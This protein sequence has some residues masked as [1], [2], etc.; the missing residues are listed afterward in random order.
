MFASLA[1]DAHPSLCDFDESKDLQDGSTMS[2]TTIKGTLLYM[3]PEPERT[4]AS[5]VFSLAVT[6]FDMLWC[7]SIPERLPIVHGKLP[8]LDV[9]AVVRTMRNT[10]QAAA[11][12]DDSVGPDTGIVELLCRMLHPEPQHRPPAVEAA[13]ELQQLVRKMQLKTCLISA[14]CTSDELVSEDGIQCSE[15]H[16]VC[17]ECFSMDV[18][19]RQVTE[20]IQKDMLHVRCCVSGCESTPFSY[21]LVA[22][23]VN[24]SAFKA[25]QDQ[26]HAVHDE[27]QQREFED[28]KQRFEEGLLKK[29]AREL[30]L[31]QIRKHVENE[32][33]TLRCPKCKLAFMEFNGCAA[34]TCKAED[35]KGTKQGGCGCAFCGFCFKD[36][37]ADAHPHV[38][39]C[40]HN[41][42][43]SVFIPLIQW[44][45]AMNERRR[46]IL[47]KYWRG[48][49]D[50]VRQEM[51][52]DGGIQQ[53][54]NDLDINHELQPV[55]HRWELEMVQIMGMGLT[56]RQVVR[57]AL[58]RAE[59]DVQAALVLLELLH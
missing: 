11:G 54:F 38:A 46:V 10:T 41:K 37:G 35:D 12:E 33:M 31:I 53:H 20:C 44:E 21:Q 4:K 39:N 43:R 15:G 55:R 8:P 26:I 2:T 19:M 59:G 28:E 23:H 50:D 27:Q 36:C 40:P 42:S 47:L 7:D 24:E 51:S 16:F 5:D 56:D 34:L 52:R 22:Q 32:I 1:A 6:L 18:E 57:D 58:E 30:E 13:G 25:L 3:P 14:A 9:G 48:L 49:N 45:T 29:S 17:S